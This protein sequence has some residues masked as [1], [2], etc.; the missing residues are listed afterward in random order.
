MELP[1]EIILSLSFTKSACVATRIGGKAVFIV[2]ALPGEIDAFRET[3]S[4]LCS[5]ERLERS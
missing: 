4:I 3:E 2:K 5:F 1:G